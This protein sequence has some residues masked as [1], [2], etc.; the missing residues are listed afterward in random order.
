MKEMF[1]WL[2][3]HPALEDSFRQGR[4][5]VLCD[6]SCLNLVIFSVKHLNMT[7]KCSNYGKD[8]PMIPIG[9][10]IRIH[11]ECDG[12]IEKSVPRITDWHHEACR[13]MTYSDREGR[14]FPTLPHSN[15]GFFFLHTIKYIILYLKRH[16]KVPENPG[17]GI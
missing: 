16:P 17:C 1:E 14:I 13:V 8:Q 6:K 3:I 9:R 2:H 12:G 15:S 4:L 5:N 10:K 11:F 7:R